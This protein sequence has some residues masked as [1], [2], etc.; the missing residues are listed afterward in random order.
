MVIYGDFLDLIMIYQLV[1]K[2]FKLA[3]ANIVILKLLT[4]K[5]RKQMA[6]LWS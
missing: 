4:N 1:S 3:Q 2:Y 5:A 6:N